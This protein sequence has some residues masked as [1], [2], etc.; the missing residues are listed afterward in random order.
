MRLEHKIEGYIMCCNRQFKQRIRLVEHVKTAHLGLKHNC[1]LCN[2]KFE[3][4]SYLMKHMAVHESLK[5]FVS[6]Q[7]YL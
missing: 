1:E 5:S 7:I 4:K 2:K 3:S 6:H